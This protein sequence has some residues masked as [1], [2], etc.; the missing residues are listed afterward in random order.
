MVMPEVQNQPNDVLTEAEAVLTEAGGPLHYRELARRIVQRG[1]W[2]TTSRTPETV[3]NVYLN[4]DLRRC[5]EASRFVSAGRGLFGLRGSTPLAAGV[6]SNGGGP[7]PVPAPAEN[8][9]TDLPRV[10]SGPA[11]SFAD[12][13]EQILLQFGAG[14]PM[15]YR[16]ITQRA[17]E[18]NLITTRGQTPHVSLYSQISTEIHRQA[19]RGETPR[20]IKLG[21]GLFGLSRRGGKGLPHRIEQHNVD[22]RRK[23]RER[24]HAMSPAEFE[25]LI[26]QLLVAIGFADV[27]VT[28]YSGD[29]GIDV[30]GTLVVGDVIRTRMAVQVKRWRQNVQAPVVQQ[31]RGSLGAHEQ[32]LIITTGGFSSGAR[33]EAEVPDRDPVALM[34]GDQ[35]VALLV[36]HNL[37]VRREPYSLLHLIETDEEATL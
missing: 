19:E 7:H 13:A 23:L 24:L 1:R 21:R 35:L 33:D 36:Q 4:N 8:P 28:N 34:D 3:L 20:F 32:G 29:G 27:S 15:H 11:L 9:G 2:A 31:V 5:G 25:A 37:G 14:Q 18:L 12:A 30:R 10:E 6:A 22:V 26:G 16:D 17:I